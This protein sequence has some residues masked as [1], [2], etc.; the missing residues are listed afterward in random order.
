MDNMCEVSETFVSRAGV[1]G[2]RQGAAMERKALQPGPDR[3]F[4]QENR[5]LSV[6]SNAN[7]TQ[8]Y[9]LQGRGL[10]GRAG[11]RGF[12]DVVCP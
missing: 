1:Y 2:G 5:V 7:G 10:A 4:R 3:S 6:G 11:G 12:A 9:A 8:A